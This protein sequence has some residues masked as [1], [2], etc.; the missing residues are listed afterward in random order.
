MFGSCVENGLQ[1][2]CGWMFRQVVVAQLHPFRT[3]LQSWFQHLTDISEGNISGETPDLECEAQ[4]SN[5]WANN[6]GIE[7]DFLQRARKVKLPSQPELR[8]H[9]HLGLREMWPS[10]SLATK[11]CWSNSFKP[12]VANVEIH[13][14]VHLQL[15]KFFFQQKSSGGISLNFYQMNSILRLSGAALILE[16]HQHAACSPFSTRFMRNNRNFHHT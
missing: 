1:F 16:F 13:L 4:K 8:R 3:R 7:I 12:V 11:K 5:Q 10:D 6:D 9:A 2:I 15:A 14:D